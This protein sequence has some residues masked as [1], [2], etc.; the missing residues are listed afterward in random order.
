MNIGIDAND[1]ILHNNTAAGS[2]SRVLIESLGE[3]CP[4]AHIYLY[5]TKVNDRVKVTP[6]LTY[7]NMRLKESKRLLFREWWRAYDG[8]LKQAKRHHVQVFHGA[9]GVLPSRIKSAG[10]P[11]VLTIN[12]LST[13][14]YPNEYGFLQRIRMKRRILNSMRRADCIIALSQT[15]RNELISHFNI[16]S[17][18]I[19]VVYPAIDKRFVSGVSPVAIDEVKRRYHLPDRFILVV[20]QLVEH[21]NVRLVV[22]ALRKVAD[23]DISLVI[24]GGKT[25]YYEELRRYAMRNHLLSRIFHIKRVHG[26][27]MA[28][29]YHCATIFAMPSR[30]EGFGFAAVEAQACGVPVIA[31]DVPVLREATANGAL[32]VDP[33]NSEQ[34]AAA[35]DRLLAE[36][37]LRQQLIAAGKDNIARFTSKNLAENMMEIYRRLRDE[38]I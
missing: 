28:A 11:S 31:S 13:F 4:K 35:I 21:K 20:S 17:E 36:N 12:D 33:D 32:Y 15:M 5:T 16:D 19:E 29:L 2:Y 3:H 10:F 1:A 26:H 14:L 23:H 9:G 38:N 8:M 22:E 7:P 24:V 25:P 37:D 6:M 30:H 27:D 34:M 18:K